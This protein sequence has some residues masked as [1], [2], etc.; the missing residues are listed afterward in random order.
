[1][2]ASPEMI[3]ALEGRDGAADVLV[4][5]RASE[6]L[7]ELAVI[8]GNGRELVRRPSSPSFMPISMGLRMGSLA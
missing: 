5:D 3:G 7:L 6:N 1:M 4:V 8:F 2:G